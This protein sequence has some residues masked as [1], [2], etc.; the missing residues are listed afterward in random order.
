MDPNKPED[1]GKDLSDGPLPHKGFDNKLKKRIEER[2]ELREEKRRKRIL[3]LFFAGGGLALLSALVLAVFPTVSREGLSAF[4]ER[5]ERQA[6]VAQTQASPEPAAAPVVKTALL[7]GL[8]TDH[9]ETDP[10]H[11]SADIGYSSYRTLLV[12][13]VDGTLSVAAEGSG[14]LMPYGTKFWRID[15]VNTETEH[16]TYQFL[17][18]YPAEKAAQPAAIFLFNPAVELSHTEKLLFAGNQ[19]L[20]VA[21]KERVWQGKASAEYSRI[22]VRKLP[23]LGLNR[24]VNFADNKKDEDHVSVQELFGSGIN[25]RLADLL[26]SGNPEGMPSQLTGE[27]W[28][29]VRNPGRWSAQVAETY[30]DSDRSEKYL[31]HDLS[32]QLPVTVTS[33]DRLGCSWSV[34]RTLQPDAKDALSSPLDDMLAV[35]TDHRLVVF[36]PVPVNGAALQEHRDPL[37]TV[38]LRPGEQLVMAQWATGGYVEDWIEKTRKFLR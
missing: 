24:V 15:E 1:F 8:R 16:G 11:P 12:A 28:T 13:P 30:T 10:L 5:N 20:S 37:L 3:P 38:E 29:V 6:T 7:I 35:L 26:G 31:L 14:I 32:E 18:P 36:A 33:Y 19:Y 4:S 17:N 25:S 2:L 21:E 22:W 9:Q 34:I 23:Q 27:S